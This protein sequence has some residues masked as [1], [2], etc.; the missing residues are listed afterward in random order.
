MVDDFAGGHTVCDGTLTAF[1]AQRNVSQDIFHDIT[2]LHLARSVGALVGVSH[3]D[4][5]L[6]HEP[7]SVG[8]TRR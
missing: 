7:S 2:E 5:L 1:P 4:E 8:D 6:L 3:E